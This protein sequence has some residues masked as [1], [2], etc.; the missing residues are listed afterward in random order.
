MLDIGVELAD[1][2]IS[3][4]VALSNISKAKLVDSYINYILGKHYTDNFASQVAT[5]GHME[6]GVVW[7]KFRE[8]LSQRNL[9]LRVSSESDSE[10]ELFMSVIADI[11]AAMRQEGI[12]A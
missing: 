2:I 4:S 3:N 1:T 5:L 11:K 12:D 7:D 10:C 8:F 9:R 6:K